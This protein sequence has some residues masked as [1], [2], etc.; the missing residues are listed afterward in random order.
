[1]TTAPLLALL[2]FTGCTQRMEMPVAAPPVDPSKSW[3]AVLEQAAGPEGVDYAYVAEHR[4]RLERFLAWVGAHGPNTETWRESSE[5]R[6]IAFGLNAYNAAVIYGVLAHQPLSSVREVQVGI[7][8]GVPGAGFFVGQRFRYDGEWLS[9]HNLEHQYLVD[10]YQEP[11]IHVGLNCA[12]RSC[13]PVQWW[14]SR[15]LQ[16]HLE[17][18]MRS[19][20]A[21]DQGLAPVGPEGANGGVTA[22]AAN[23]L[24]QWYADDFTDWSSADTVCGYL[25]S[26]AGGARK[27]WLAAHADDCPLQ[28][29]PYDWSLND[30]PGTA[31]LR[32]EPSPASETAASETAG[33]PDTQAEE[34]QDPE[35]PD[36][37]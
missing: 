16:A 37:P 27:R 33:E 21:S 36:E 23:E 30:A 14:D 25:V 5:D 24:F 17:R 34:V 26:Y 15:G 4:D 7:F 32:A 31:A 19:F 3:Q 13:P 10:R 11:L 22:W 28:Y 6:R 9:L 2:L 1:M 18:A 29:R 35:D 20:L 12:S 8:R